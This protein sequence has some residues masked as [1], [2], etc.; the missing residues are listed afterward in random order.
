VNGYSADSGKIGANAERTAAGR[1]LR[2]KSDELCPPLVPL[3]VVANRVLAGLV[4]LL[5]QATRKCLGGLDVQSRSV[6]KQ[7]CPLPEGAKFKLVALLSRS[8]VPYELLRP[9][10]FGRLHPRLARCS[11]LARRSRLVEKLLRPTP[12]PVT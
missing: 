12:W 11:R 9:L 5:P 8:P 3:L 4:P 10:D 7:I 2:A 1:L 6:P